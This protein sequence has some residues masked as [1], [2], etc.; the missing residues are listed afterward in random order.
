MC[1]C[2]RMYVCMSMYVNVCMYVIMYVY[3]HYARV[4]VHTYILKATHVW[5]GTRTKSNLS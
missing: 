5:Y 3:T 1:A 2:V 4:Y